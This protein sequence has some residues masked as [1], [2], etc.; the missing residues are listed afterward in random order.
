MKPKTVIVMVL[1][2]FVFGSVA[3]LVINEIGSNAKSVP[4]SS[5][6]IKPTAQS[7][8]KV[9]VYY[10][11]GNVRCS[12]CRNFEAYSNE[13]M[14][15]AFAQELKSGRLEWRVTNVDEASNQHY[16]EDYRL[17]T[18]SVIVAKMQDG[19]QVEWKNLPRIWEL[20]G[21]KPAF[22]NYIQTEVTAYLGKGA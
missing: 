14:Q 2:V 8:D 19:R 3:Y 16:I 5:T 11:H 13:I 9:V 15:K 6:S 1:L 22:M 10:F 12:N 20:V 17:I 7:G 18:R 4:E 21:D